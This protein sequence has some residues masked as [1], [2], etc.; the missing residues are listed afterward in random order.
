MNELKKKK[1]AIPRSRLS[2]YPSAHPNENWKRET[3]LTKCTPKEKEALQRY[4][5]T[6]EDM[7]DA[8]FNRGELAHV[9]FGYKHTGEKANA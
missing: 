5:L 9:L 2:T 4:G 7:M 6:V 8:G 3:D 1:I